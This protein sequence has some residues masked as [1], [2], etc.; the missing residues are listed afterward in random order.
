MQASATKALGEEKIGKLLLKLATPAIL[1]QII[2]LL[3]TIVDRIYIGRMA[4]VGA[5][6]LTGVGVCL[7][8]I[9]TNA[10]FAALGGMGGA[11]RASM[12]LGKGDVE[13]AEKTLGNSASLLIIFSLI[14]TFVYITFGEQ[15]LFLIGASENTIGYAN[16][17][18]SIYSIGSIFVQITLGLNFFITAQGF[19]KTSMLTVLIGA[20][21]NII[22]DP[23]F[24]FVF[25]MGVSGAALATI[26]SQAVSMVW[27]LIFLTGKKSTLQLKLKRLKLKPKIFLPILALGLSP[28]IMYSTESLLNITFNTSL[29]KYGGD[30]AVGAMTIL[31]SVMQIAFLPLTGLV[32]GAQPIV[33]YNYGANN[34]SRVKKAFKYLLISSMIYSCSYW[35][36]TQL[37]PEAFVLMF[38]SDPAL[39]E[40]TSGALRVYTFGLFIFGA[41]LACQNTFLALG[42]AKSSL[43]LA[44]LRKIILLI[45]LIYILP[46]FFEDKTFAVFLAEPVADITAA[47]CTIALFAVQFKKAIKAIEN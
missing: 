30:L 31:A 44:L 25:D 33:S 21:L 7:P 14:I 2:N 5:L 40:F 38:N 11:P 23:I 17:Y 28:F 3:Y 15:I 16:E 24:I 10:A 42:N 29:A 35:L 27:I 6:A 37:F 4:D 34:A 22:L 20:V 12:Q 32:Q 41:Q 9:M 46:H 13:G 36:L 39:V 43:F 1:A 8:L 45:P 19:A 47:I 18:L 26:I